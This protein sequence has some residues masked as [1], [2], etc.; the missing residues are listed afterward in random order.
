MTF[1]GIG[2]PAASVVAGEA[3]RE[4]QC[5]EGGAEVA[6]EAAPGGGRLVHGREDRRLAET[7]PQD[8]KNGFS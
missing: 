5:G 8:E 4:A 3:G 2:L 7:V 1:F 6:E